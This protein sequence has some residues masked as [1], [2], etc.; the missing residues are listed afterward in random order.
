M[1]ALEVLQSHITGKIFAKIPKSFFKIFKI[2]QIAIFN[3]FELK[4]LVN[5]KVFE[6]RFSLTIF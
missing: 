1:N 3:S 4:N 2:R 5:K 6:K